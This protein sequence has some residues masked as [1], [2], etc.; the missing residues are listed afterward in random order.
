[1]CQIF[2]SLKKYLIKIKKEFEFEFEN[3]SQISPLDE[4]HFTPSAQPVRPIHIHLEIRHKFL[5]QKH[6]DNPGVKN[7]WL[8]PKWCIHVFRYEYVFV[9]LW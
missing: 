2:W 7:Y 4:F 6:V 9:E 1:M 8:V 3:V 5:L